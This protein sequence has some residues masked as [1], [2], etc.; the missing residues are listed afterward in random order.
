MVNGAVEVI[1]LVPTGKALVQGQPEAIG[2]GGDNPE[3]R[4]AD[5]PE[6]I[7]LLRADRAWGRSGLQR[8]RESFQQCG[9]QGPMAKSAETIAATLQPRA[10]SVLSHQQG[11]F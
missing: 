9:A 5:S 4:Q 10:F 1:G 2:C 8:S 7:Q 3:G 11:Y 6:E